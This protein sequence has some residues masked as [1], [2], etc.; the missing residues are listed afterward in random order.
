MDRHIS[1]YLDIN[2]SIKWRIVELQLFEF[3]VG[4]FKVD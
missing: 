4:E 3:K 2:F 1:D